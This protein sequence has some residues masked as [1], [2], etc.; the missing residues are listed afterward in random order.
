MRMF[1]V[2]GRLHFQTSVRR[3]PIKA[4]AA[5]GSTFLDFHL[6]EENPNKDADENVDD[7]LDRVLS[8]TVFKFFIH[9]WPVRTMC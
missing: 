6:N 9:A 8:P 3:S 7:M 1:E 5:G 2:L 4:L